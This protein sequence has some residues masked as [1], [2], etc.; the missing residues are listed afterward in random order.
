MGILGSAA[1]LSPV[2]L[3][4]TSAIK[5]RRPSKGVDEEVIE[6]ELE[7]KLKL[8]LEREPVNRSRRATLG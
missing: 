7:L 3:P 2:A 1:S 6:V 5:K 4:G 8:E